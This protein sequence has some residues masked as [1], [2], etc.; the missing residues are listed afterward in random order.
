LNSFLTQY[1]TY[2]SKLEN[3]ET[4]FHH[5]GEAPDVA[6]YVGWYRLRHYED[7]FTFR[8]G[9]IGYHMASAEAVSL[10]SASEPGWCKN[11]LDHG[12]TATLGSIGEPYLD[13]FPEPLEFAAL[14]MT[15]QYSLVEAYYL[16]SRWI[17]WR[18]VLVGDPLYN[19]WKTTPA[20]KRSTLTMFPLAPIAPSDRTFDDPIIIRGEWARI[21]EQSR[22][23]L[24]AILRDQIQPAIQS[25]P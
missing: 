23:K 2:Q 7:A 13:A 19:P 11:A 21:H 4:R 18:M 1:T 24:D 22:T 16:T 25:A 10:H 12:I 8:S 5:P 3:T 20:A 6:L 14:L 15:G 17:S 9:A